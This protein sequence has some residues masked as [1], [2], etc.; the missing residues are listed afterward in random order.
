MEW[1]WVAP[2]VR[3]GQTRGA[4]GMD[5][6]LLDLGRVALRHRDILPVSRRPTIGVDRTWDSPHVT[7]V[8]DRYRP[9]AAHPCTTARICLRGR[10]NWCTP[11]IDR[12]G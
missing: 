12:P 5:H 8:L 4:G 6:V 11:T 3:V 1:P 9:S 2:L 10:S 7:E